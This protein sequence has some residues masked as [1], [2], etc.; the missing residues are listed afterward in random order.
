MGLKPA[1]WLLAANLLIAFLSSPALAVFS[2]FV[3]IPFGNTIDDASTKYCVRGQA[4]GKGNVVY[5]VHSASQGW[6]ALGIGPTVM[7]GGDAVIGWLNSTGSIQI[8]SILTGSYSI[9]NNPYAPWKKLFYNTSEETPPSWA[10][11]SY[12]VLHPLNPVVG[13]GNPILPSPQLT[14]YIYAYSN[15]APMN[16]DDTGKAY[17]FQHDKSGIFSGDLAVSMNIH[18]GPKPFLEYGALKSLKNTNVVHGAI[19]F[20][21]WGVS[22]FVG[23]FIARYLKERLG[24]WWYRLHIIFMF[25]ICV[26]LSFCAFLIKVLTKT[27]PHF[28]STHECLGIAIIVVMFLQVILGYITDALYDPNRIRAP[29][30]DQ[31]HWWIGRGLFI[32]GLVNVVLGMI[33]YNQMT[34]DDPISSTTY[35]ILCGWVMLGFAAFVYGEYRLVD[36]MA[37][38]RQEAML[39][40]MKEQNS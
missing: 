29:W 30:Y 10:Q 1:G 26:G 13:Q 33:A 28:V 15:S 6:A 23:I 3:C 18:E 7:K 36:Q 8:K 37:L 17:F 2:T 16:L 12:S 27:P 39:L 11:I 25:P 21:A 22:P 20:I 14:N 9:S 5:T 31:L 38:L 19:M 32:G 4:D 24:V 34:P 40:N 35:G